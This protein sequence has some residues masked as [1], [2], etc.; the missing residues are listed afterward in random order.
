MGLMVSDLD[1]CDKDRAELAKAKLDIERLTSDLTNTQTYYVLTK[2][3]V[4]RLQ[5]YNDSLVQQNLTLSVDGGK[6]A[7]RLKKSRNWWIVTA[8]TATLTVIG[9]HYHWKEANLND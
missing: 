8:F 9:V 7:A 3:E 4:S 2:S 5:N 6:T 1:Q